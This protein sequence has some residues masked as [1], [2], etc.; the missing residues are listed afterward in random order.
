VKKLGIMQIV[1]KISAAI[2]ILNDILAAEEIVR[3]I[4]SK[5]RDNK[6]PTKADGTAW[7]HEEIAAKVLEVYKIWHPE[8]VK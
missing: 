8:D 3:A 2:P 7:T 4:V 6:L 1:G 5:I